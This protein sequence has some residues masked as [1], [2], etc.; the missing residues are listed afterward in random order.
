MAELT[1]EAFVEVFGGG[2]F[3]FSLG[4]HALLEGGSRK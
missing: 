4:I 3:R 2:T 1:G